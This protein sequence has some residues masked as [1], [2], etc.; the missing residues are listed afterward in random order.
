M[1]MRGKTFLMR[2]WM[3]KLIRCVPCGGSG[4]VMGG[5]MMM[6]DCF[7]CDG[8]GKIHEEEKI[9]LTAIENNKPKR[10]RPKRENHG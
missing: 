2:L 3:S 1:S 7:E 6:K 8:R 9:P 4:I 10:G 5:G